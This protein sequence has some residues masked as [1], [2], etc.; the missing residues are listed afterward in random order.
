M[1]AGFPP[2]PPPEKP[3]EIKPDEIYHL[4]PGS[5]SDMIYQ[6]MNKVLSPPFQDEKTLEVVQ[7]GWKK[8]AYAIARGVVDHL[9]SQAEVYGVKT[10]GDV[11][12]TVEGDVGTQKGATFEQVSGTGRLK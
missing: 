1:K 6:E 8:L 3:D 12:V 11:T 10:Q 7:E 2:P 9:T 4:E 5:M